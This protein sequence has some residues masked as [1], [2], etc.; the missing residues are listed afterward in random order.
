MC[1]ITLCLIVPVVPQILSV[2]RISGL[3]AILSWIPLT[4]DQA[5]GV[6]TQ[7]RIAYQLTKTSECSHFNVNEGDIMY[8]EGNLFVQSQVTLNDLKPDEEYCVAIQVSTVAGSS[9]L[10]KPLKIKCEFNFI[11]PRNNN[12]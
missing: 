3:T 6:L 2:D 4:P 9:G 7:L 5:S 10:S 12:Y 1:F 8:L 11:P